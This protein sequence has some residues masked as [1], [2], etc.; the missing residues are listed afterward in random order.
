M[1]R[2]APMG[3]PPMGAPRSVTRL[4]PRHAGTG[5]PTRLEARE[6]SSHEGTVHL[7]PEQRRPESDGASSTADATIPDDLVPM[8]D[9]LA[10]TIVEAL[11]F[12]VAVVNIARPDGSLEVVSVAGDADARSTLLGHV[13]SAETWEQ[14]LS[15]SE[16]WGRLR[17][18]DHRNEEADTTSLS[19]VPDLVPIDAE[20]AWHPEDSLF[21]PLTSADGTRLGILSVDLPREGRRPDDASR[22]SLEAFAMATAL[23]I[24][25]STLRSRAEASERISRELATH[26]PLT[27]LGNRSMMIE[28]LEHAATSRAEQRALMAL[29]F[30]DLDGFKAINDVHSH[31]AGDA[32]LHEVAQRIRSVV[33]PHDTVVRWGGDEFLVLLE[34]LDD[35]AAGRGVAERITRAVAAP[36]PFAGRELGVTASVGLAFGAGG[37]QMDPDAL[38]RRADAAMYQVKKDGR[39]GCA[40]YV[41]TPE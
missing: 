15:R 18:A 19:W 3:A 41:P 33:R 21:A 27:G 5:L 8:L 13:D 17:F 4:V 22:R 6:A 38:V 16:Q 32:V 11:G 29:V 7:S 26:D 28:R 35:E 31:A 34:N 14:V 39:N 25:H 12:G 2:G 37:R 30:I 24:E 10:G 1:T 36:V 20:D 9:E 23:A 40:V